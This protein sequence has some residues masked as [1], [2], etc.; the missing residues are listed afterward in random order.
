M[1]DDRIQEYGTGTAPEQQL[2]RD[3]YDRQRL[4]SHQAGM[5]LSEGVRIDGDDIA[6][7]AD[8]YEDDQV[9]HTGTHE[10]LAAYD[11]EY[12]ASDVFDEIEAIEDRIVPGAQLL[13]LAMDTLDDIERI[14]SLEFDR[15]VMETEVVRLRHTDQQ[16][17]LDSYSIEKAVNDAYEQTG[18]LTVGHGQDHSDAYG[19]LLPIGMGCWDR[20]GDVLVG[21]KDVTADTGFDPDAD[22]TFTREALSGTDTPAGRIQQYRNTFTDPDGDE[23]SYQVTNLHL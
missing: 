3:D 10:E 7:F 13:S 2:R 8:V 21:Y 22:L 18:E 1:T 16:D 14:E 11:E 23:L 17:G 15:P 6:V 4:D 5:D 12:G 20:E 9:L 19:S